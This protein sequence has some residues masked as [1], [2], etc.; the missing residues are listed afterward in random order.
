MHIRP[1]LSLGRSNLPWASATLRENAAVGP[2]G[3]GLARGFACAKDA[4]ANTIRGVTTSATVRIRNACVKS[5][6]GMRRGERPDTARTPTSKPSTPKRRKL[7][8]QLAKSASQ[9]VE[10]PKLAP[11]RGHA[12][13]T[14]SSRF[15]CAIGRAATNTPLACAATWHATAALPAV[16]P[17]GL[18]WIVNANGSRATPWRGGRSGPSSTKPAPAPRFAPRPHLQPA[19]VSATSTVTVLPRRRR[20]SI[21]A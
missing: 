8:R 20:S 17:F 7:R 21:I 11:E 14:F 10:N 1:G 18:S 12:A 4:G 3:A 5:A 19:A 13:Q 9:T 16:R 6:A 15:H 2:E